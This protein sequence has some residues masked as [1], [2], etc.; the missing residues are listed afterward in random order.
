[1]IGE[2]MGKALNGQINAELYSAYLA[3]SQKDNAA[4]VFLHL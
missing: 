1:M 4:E 2:K 3:R